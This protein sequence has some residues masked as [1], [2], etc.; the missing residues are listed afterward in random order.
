VDELPQKKIEE[1]K[2]IMND[3]S[4]EIQARLVI[5]FMANGAINING[6]I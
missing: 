6:P 3:A 1:I 5:D 2:G 4:N